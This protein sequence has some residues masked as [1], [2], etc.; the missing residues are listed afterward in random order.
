MV[1][2]H[3]SEMLGEVR[4]VPTLAETEN[5]Y[6]QYYNALM[7]TTSTWHIDVLALL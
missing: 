6:G 2:V 7:S 3:D 5:V 1:H 4:Y